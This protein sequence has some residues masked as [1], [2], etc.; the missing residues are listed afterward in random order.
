M[1]AVCTGMISVALTNLILVGKGPAVQ[2]QRNKAQLSK[3]QNV[4]D[5]F[6]VYDNTVSLAVNLIRIFC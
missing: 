1:G 5:M 2:S 6:T 4:L 3:G